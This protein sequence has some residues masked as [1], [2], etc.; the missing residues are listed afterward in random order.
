MEE[1]TILDRVL[2]EDPLAE[3]Y[4]SR[5]WEEVRESREYLG[6]SIP[7]RGNTKCRGPGVGVYLVFLK[8]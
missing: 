2:R 3:W 8:E 5:D 6:K 4:F 7:V 1:G